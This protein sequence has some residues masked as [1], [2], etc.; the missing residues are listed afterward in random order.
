MRRKKDKLDK[1]VDTKIKIEYLEVNNCIKKM[2]LAAN[3]RYIC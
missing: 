3:R 1:L 2:D